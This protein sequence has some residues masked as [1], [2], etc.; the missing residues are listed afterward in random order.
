MAISIC[1]LNLQR[2]IAANIDD[3]I[4]LSIFES[5]RPLVDLTR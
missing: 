5:G 2:S 1:P 4:A 3:L